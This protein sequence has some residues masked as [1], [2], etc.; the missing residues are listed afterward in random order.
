MIGYTFTAQLRKVLG[1][2]ARDETRRLRHE[3][4]GTEHLLLALTRETEGGSATVLRHLDI[5]PERIRQKLEETVVP[6]SGLPIGPDVPFTARAKRALD[7]AIQECVRTHAAVADTEQLLV[8]LCA[9]EKG[10]AAQVLAWAGLTTDVARA[11]V[12]QLTGARAEPPLASARATEVVSV[13]VEARWSDGSVRRE[14]FPSVAA[15][16]EYLSSQR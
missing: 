10:I 6:G 7:L 4:I 5:A 3:Y 16:M 13:T 15:A 1:S 2:G 14:V 12:D 8:G 11:A 9:E